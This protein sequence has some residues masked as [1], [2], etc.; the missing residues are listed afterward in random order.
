MRDAGTRISLLDLADD[1][2]FAAFYQVSPVPGIGPMTLSSAL[3]RNGSSCKAI[4]GPG[5]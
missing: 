1:E 3:G 4:P 5:K 2:Q